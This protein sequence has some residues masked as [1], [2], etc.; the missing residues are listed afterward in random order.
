[1]LIYIDFLVGVMV[2]NDGSSRLNYNGRFGMLFCLI[3]MA[4]MVNDEP[5]PMTTSNDDAKW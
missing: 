5:W 1:M 3:V 4:A 2:I